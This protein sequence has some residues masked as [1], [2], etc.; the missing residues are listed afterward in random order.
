MRDMNKRNKKR[1]SQEPEKR[2]DGKKAKVDQAAKNKKKK[3]GQK[4]RKLK[5]LAAQQQASNTP[6]L[7][8]P[9]ALEMSSD[10]DD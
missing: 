5:K 2:A 10:E 7:T 1:K 6:Q 9:T 3:L 8:I 4:A